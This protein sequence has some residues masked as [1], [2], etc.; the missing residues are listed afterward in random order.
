MRL[1]VLCSEYPPGPHG[2]I[3]TR[4]R[5]LCRHLVAAGHEVRVVGAYPRDYPAPDYEEDEGVRVWRLREGAGRFGWVGAW[6]RQYRRVRAW[7]EGRGGRPRRGPG[8]P[9]VVRALAPAAGPAR[10]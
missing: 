4:Y 2:G 9:G 3:G 5:I 1:C 7:I 6:R 10:P 8:Q